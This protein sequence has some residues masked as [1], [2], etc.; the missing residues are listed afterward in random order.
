MK[1]LIHN[2]INLLSFS[3]FQ[4]N[5]DIQPMSAF[6]WD[7][8]F[9]TAKLHNTLRLVTH[10]IASGEYGN[11]IFLS[12]QAA[13][14]INSSEKLTDKDFIAYTLN[15][16]NDNNYFASYIL[17]KRMRRIIYNEHHSIDTSVTSLELLILITRNTTDILNHGINILGI[18]Q[19]GVFLRAKGHKVDYVK[20]EN[21]LHKL[22]LH[23]MAAYIGSILIYIFGLEEN[24][25]PFIGK[26]RK[27]SKYAI[28]RLMANTERILI[29]RHIYPDRYEQD[30]K[31]PSR[32]EITSSLRYWK[33][34]PL[35]TTSRFFTNSVRHI[36][37]IEE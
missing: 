2:Y 28:D 11:S 19:L 14:E 3:A 31:L 9:E 34:I 36:T 22:S 7:I 25:I 33:Y 1:A 6:K 20:L 30:R 15:L 5:A 16:S 12:S 35:E 23:D 24:E 21:W 26:S 4:N 17:N 10:A 13:Q 32:K 37:E 8:L 18:L 29:R 27:S